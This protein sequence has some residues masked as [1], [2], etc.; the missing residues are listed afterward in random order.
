MAEIESVSETDT[1]DS[2]D[3]GYIRC[4][5]DIFKI[6]NPQQLTNSSTLSKTC[7]TFA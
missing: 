4:M 7:P 3:F 6:K 5:Y 2:D 1:K